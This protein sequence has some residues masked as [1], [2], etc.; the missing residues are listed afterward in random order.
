MLT[1][2]SAIFTVL[3]SHT[4]LGCNM[5]ITLLACMNP[6]VAN[7]HV[8]RSKSRSGP[9]K[10]QIAARIAIAY[11]TLR[12]QSAIRC[13]K[14]VEFGRPWYKHNVS[15]LVRISSGREFTASKREVKPTQSGD[16]A[17]PSLCITL[18]IFAVLL[19]ASQA[20]N[21]SDL[22]GVVQSVVLSISVTRRGRILFSVLGCVSS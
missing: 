5:G 12:R 1:C 3:V 17:M 19:G 6:V 8:A 13:C 4:A 9:T 10:R 11:G 7:V 21:T 16:Q 20:Q 2:Y 18:G 22:Y 15:W 14:A